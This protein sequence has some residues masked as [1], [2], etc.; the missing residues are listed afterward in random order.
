MFSEIDTKTLSAIISAIRKSFVRS[1]TFQIALHQAISKE[2]GPRG[3][4]MRICKHCNGSFSDREVHVDHIEPVVPLDKTIAEMTL[5]EY[6]SR[7][8]QCHVDNLQVLCTACHKLKTA[9]ENEER[10]RFRN[11]KKPK[12]TSKKKKVI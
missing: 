12:V 5:N 6:Y 7:C 2:V 10:K 11:L 3:G 8:S 1:I 4:R 9:S